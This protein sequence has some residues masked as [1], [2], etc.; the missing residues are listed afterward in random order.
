MAVVLQH[1][2]TEDAPK[3]WPTLGGFVNKAARRYRKDYHLDDMRQ[4]IFDGDA[5]LFGVFVNSA[6]MAAIVTSE[7][8]YPKRDIMMIELVGGSEMRLWFDDAIDQLTD[9]AQAGGYHAIIS[10]ARLGWRDRKSVV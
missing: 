6:P 7:M 2:P 8:I 5:A 4:A 9:F 10:Q 1:I 3:W